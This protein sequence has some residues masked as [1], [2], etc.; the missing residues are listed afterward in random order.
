MGFQF[1]IEHANIVSYLTIA[2]SKIPVVENR[3][4]LSFFGSLID[5]HGYQTSRLI[6]R[7]S[8][9]IESITQTSSDI[10]ERLNDVL[11]GRLDDDLVEPEVFLEFTNPLLEYFREYELYALI[12]ASDE[13]GDVNA[14]QFFESAARNSEGMGLFLLPD[15]Q[16]TD[17]TRH[18]SDENKLQITFLD[19]DPIIQRM[20]TA[21][22][23]RPSVLFWTAAG[24]SCILPLKEARRAYDAEFGPAMKR[25]DG[26]V[27]NL[28][29]E[30]A[31]RAKYN[32][33]LHLSDLHLGSP[34][35][36][37]KKITS[38]SISGIFT[39]VRGIS[40]EL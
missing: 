14:R 21:P 15:G 27:D 9:W 24:G 32:R 6:S 12:L 11:R 36:I 38:N 30:A 33:I 35:L 29:R 23:A 8:D 4:F 25:R 3:V 17:F 31:E 37:R 5:V 18:R 22:V 28:L 16:P 39:A 13:S 40:T 10:Y 26:T 34:E 1:S 2:N 20:A 19:P 7:R